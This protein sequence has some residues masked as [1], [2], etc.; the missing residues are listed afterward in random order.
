MPSFPPSF[1][2][3]LEETEKG[4]RCVVNTYKSITVTEGG[5]K[6]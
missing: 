5:E 2:S 4:N 6:K 3:N 1:I